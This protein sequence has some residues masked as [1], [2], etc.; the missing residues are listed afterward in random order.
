VTCGTSADLALVKGK[1]LTMNPLQ[2]LA[3]AVAVKADRILKVG[4]NGEVAKF[5]G[6][7]TLVIDLKGKTVLPGF[8]DTHIHVGDFGRMLMWLNLADVGSIKEL[9]QLLS[10]RVRRIAAGR[11][12]VGRGWDEKCF[13]EKRLP[14]RFDL[15]AVSPKNPVIFYYKCGPVCVV[16]SKALELAG[17]TKDTSAPAGGAIDK[18]AT[19]EPTGILRETATDLVWRV[20]PEPTEA[21]LIGRAGVYQNS[22]GRH[23]KHPLASYIRR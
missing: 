11:W 8:I 6:K 21:E 3:E 7:N 18:D 22:G 15:D 2:P 13:A 12:V 5:I 20:I 4:T 19:G 23:H 17:I 16:N 1:I 14:S 9:Q 10:D